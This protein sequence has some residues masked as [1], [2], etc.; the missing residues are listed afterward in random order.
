MISSW[1]ISP[2]DAKILLDYRKRGI[3]SRFDFYVGEIFKNGYRNSLDILKEIVEPCG[4][5]I[6]R[7]RNH[8][9]V[10]VCIGEKYDAVIECL[11][12][13][14]VNPRCEQCCITIDSELANFYIDFFNEIIDFDGRYKNWKP[15]KKKDKK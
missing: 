15:Y 5:R 1:V 4:G 10:T 3:V 13:L 14:N 2:E 7:F 11:A 9:K 8:A 12:N 6:A